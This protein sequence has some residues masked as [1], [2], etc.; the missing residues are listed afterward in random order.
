MTRR[1]DVDTGR[2]AGV[3]FVFLCLLLSPSIVLGYVLWVAKLLAARGSATGTAQG[4]L[5]ARWMQHRLG[6]REDDAAA[7][8]LTR[9]PTVSPVAVWLVFGPM[10]LAH[11]VTGH[12]PATFRY[13]F[14]GDVTIR[15]QAAARQ[16]FYDGVVERA[17]ADVSQLVV[18]G[19][20]FDTRTLRGLPRRVRAFEVDT[21]EV[22]DA[23]LTALNASHLD[24]AAVSFVRAD[25][26]RDDWIVELTN[27]G[28]DPTSPTLF[29]WEGVTPY[30]QASSVEAALERIGRCAP[31]SVL[32][33]DVLTAEALRSRALTMRVVR[34]SLQAGGEPLTFGVEAAPSLDAALRS[35]L[36][37]SG[38]R[39]A[40]CRPVPPKRPVGAFVVAEVP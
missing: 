1:R 11:R 14:A 10:L 27:A 30:L 40:E 20:G 2:G 34:A 16:T 28:F 33:F 23:K 15:N 21:P 25:F 24:T 17:L 36:S 18:L 26:D 3:A 35:L 12:V 37:P 7:R 5:S 19:A 4:P 8:L 39:L 38:L 22:V 29:L 31:G 13:P 9:L 6:V 32:A